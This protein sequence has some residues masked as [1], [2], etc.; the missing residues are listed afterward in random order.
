[1]VDVRPTERLT[2]V[3]LLA[4][5][6][7]F[8]AVR[9]PGTIAALALLAGLAG[10]LWAVARGGERR[11][12]AGLLRDLLPVAGILVVY[13]LLQPL[14]EAVNPARWDGA[15]AALDARWFGALPDRW[16]GLLGRPARLVDAAYLAYVSYY[17]LP[18]GVYLACR[19]REPRDGER[20]GVTLLATFYL[21]YL[22]YLAMP[23][24]GPRVP[25]AEEALL[26]GGAVSEAVRAFLGAAELTTLDAFPSGH[27]ALSLLPALLAASRFPRVAPALAAWAA[28]I[29]FSTIYIHVHYVTDLAAGVALVGI[30]LLVGPALHRALGGEAPGPAPAGGLT[31]AE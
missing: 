9:P 7:A 16:H 31:E 18:L 10:A 27:T 14:I 4:L 29:V 17:G 5:A 8:A 28:A 19:W 13:G 11:G 2:L 3:V 21:S 15:L 24:S 30:G 12:V 23:A 6:A 22:G 20:V 25:R 1:V 26:G